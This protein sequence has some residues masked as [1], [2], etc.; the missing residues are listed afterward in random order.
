MGVDYRTTV[1]SLFDGPINT[2]LFRVRDESEAHT[3]K[4]QSEVK[5]SDPLH[6]QETLLTFEKS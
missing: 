2:M 1:K 3:K 5:V 6:V 4:W